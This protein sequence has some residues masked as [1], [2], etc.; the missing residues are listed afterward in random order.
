MSEERLDLL[1]IEEA[2]KRLLQ[3]DGITLR[4]SVDDPATLWQCYKA[5]SVVEEIMGIVKGCTCPDLDFDYIRGV[6]DVAYP[7]WCV[8]GAE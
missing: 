2:K 4:K 7:Y 6:L 8:E 1:P 3:E 5:L